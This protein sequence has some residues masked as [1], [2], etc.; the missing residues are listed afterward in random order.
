MSS[1]LAP[2]FLH[3]SI[4]FRYV[5]VFSPYS[6]QHKNK[7]C[8][9]YESQFSFG[10]SNNHSVISYVKTVNIYPRRCSI[11]GHEDPRPRC[12]LKCVISY[13]KTV[14]IYPRRCSIQG[15]ED[16]RPRCTLKC[17]ISYVKTVNIYPRRCSIQGHEDP[18][19]R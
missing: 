10:Q 2:H 12:T 9:V 4:I 1:I 18:H 14:N 5:V 19:P 8:E 3:V 15:H 13:V 6:L 16:P 11:Q 17:V 7:V